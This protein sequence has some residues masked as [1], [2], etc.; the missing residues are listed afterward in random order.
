MLISKSLSTTVTSSVGSRHSASGKANHSKVAKP[1]VPIFWAN[2]IAAALLTATIL[3]LLLFP[4]VVFMRAG[5]S[6]TSQ[7]L[8]EQSAAPRAVFYPQPPS[9]KW[10]HAYADS[11]GALWQSEP[12]QRFMRFC[13]KNRESPYWNPYSGCGQLGPETLVDL[14]FFL[15]NSFDCTFRRKSDGFQRCSYGFLLYCHHDPVLVLCSLA[16]DVKFCGT[17]IMHRL[18]LLTDTTHGNDGLEYFTGLFVF[19][20][21]LYALVSFAA[22]PTSLRFV[23]LIPVDAAVLSAT[24][25][26]NLLAHAFDHSYLG[27]RLLRINIGKRFAPDLRDNSSARICRHPCIFRLGISLLSDRRKFAAC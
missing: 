26:P 11:G 15:A 8:G 24:F 27:A 7:Y 18:F 6:Q 3:V 1:A 2:E 5:L 22:K 20:L 23:L 9:R 19:P 17:G 4:D 12:A 14:K 16:K 25:L 13:L 10:L 21:L